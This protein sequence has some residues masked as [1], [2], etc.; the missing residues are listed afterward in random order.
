MTAKQMRRK[1]PINL[2]HLKVIEPLTDNQERVFT[3]YAEGKHLVLHGA[4]GASHSSGGGADK[5]RDLEPH[6]GPFPPALQRALALGL[7]ERRSTS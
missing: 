4:A 2:D 7:V 3:S 5:Y 1:K 6:A